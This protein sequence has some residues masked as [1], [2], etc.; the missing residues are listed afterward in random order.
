MTRKN[1]NTDASVVDTLKAQVQQAKALESISDQALL[2]DPRLNPATRGEA[3]RLEAERLRAS[4]DAEHRRKLRVL[5]EQDAREAERLRAAEA[6]V[7][8]RAATDPA[9]TLLEV[10]RLRSRVVRWSLVASVALSVGSA[11]GMEAALHGGVEGAPVGVGYLAELAGTVLATVAILWRGALARARA[12]VTQTAH[13]AFLA[14]IV[15]PLAVS[16]VG[17]TI[18]SGPVGAVCSLGAAAF[19]VL[20]YLVNTSS[21]TAVQTLLRRMTPTPADTTTEDDSDLDT[22]PSTLPRRTPGDAL[23]GAGEDLA[24]A[25]TA[26]LSTH[27]GDHRDTEGGEHGDTEGGEHGDTEGGEHGAT[28]T[29]TITEDGGDHGARPVVPTP[30]DDAPA[31]PRPTVADIARERAR[32]ARDRVHRYY[33]EHPDTTVSGAAKALGMDRKTV[34]KYRPEEGEQE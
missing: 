14:M 9:V 20:A 8:A 7:S 31:Q 19:S 3:D 17:S 30:E 12:H 16:A 27:G 1:R 2:S 11:M 13:R 22:D 23:E 18:G 5:R 24:G 26:Y 32:L 10:S 28:G 21:A 15:V 33:R 4:L 34:S 29:D 6:V 25:F